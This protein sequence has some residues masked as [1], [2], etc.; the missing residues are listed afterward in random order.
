MRVYVFQYEKD[1][2][3]YGQW[4]IFAPSEDV[5]RMELAVKYSL[6]DTPIELVEV[7]EDRRRET[8]REGDK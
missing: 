8:R 6:G 1:G 5:A 2:T 3:P 4:S 7:M